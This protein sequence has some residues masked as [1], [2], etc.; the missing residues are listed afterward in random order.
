VTHKDEH[1]NQTLYASKRSEKH[2][3]IV[4]QQHGI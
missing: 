1:L 4:M 3:M 2:D